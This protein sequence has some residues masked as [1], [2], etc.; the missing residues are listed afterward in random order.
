MT[1]VEVQMGNEMLGELL[2]LNAFTTQLN[3]KANPS[4]SIPSH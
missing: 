2:R 1:Q 3:N 4:E